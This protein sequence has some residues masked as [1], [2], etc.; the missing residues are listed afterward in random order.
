V[1]ALDVGPVVDGVLV[2][3]ELAQLTVRIIAAEA[4]ITHRIAEKVAAQ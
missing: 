1:G 4:P 2:V 3:W